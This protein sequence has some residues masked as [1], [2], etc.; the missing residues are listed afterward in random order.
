MEQH[1]SQSTLSRITDFIVKYEWLVLAFLL[2]LV[3]FPR[4]VS[5]ILLLI[6][7]VLWLVRKLNT[8]HFIIGTPADWTILLLLVMLLVSLYATFD[9][10]YSTPKVIGIVYGIAMFYAATAFASRS[11]RHLFGG[12]A[13]L[14]LSGLV[15]AIA[16][17]LGTNWTIKLPFL[18]VVTGRLP[19]LIRLESAPAGFSPNQVAGALL[20]VIPVYIALTIVGVTEKHLM[21]QRAGMD[22][23]GGACCWGWLRD[24]AGDAIAYPVSEGL[25]RVGRCTFFMAFVAD[26]GGQPRCS[27]PGP[28]IAC[29]GLLGAVRIRRPTGVA[30]FAQSDSNRILR[31]NIPII[32]VRRGVFSRPPG[33]L[34]SCSLRY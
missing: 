12:V 18:S 14:L 9:L 23:L 29:C 31:G 33:N 27:A 4:P 19:Q 30:T 34:V 15:V 28:T 5:A 20:W 32:A 24:Y 10:A 6:I 22:S 1:Q 2:P 25:C 17:L 8:G 21:R 16:S 7:P 3:L 13:A 11:Q 26:P